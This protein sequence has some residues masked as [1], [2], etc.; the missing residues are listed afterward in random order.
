MSN[1]VIT[2]TFFDFPVNGYDILQ[3]IETH[4][5]RGFF[6]VNFDGVNEVLISSSRL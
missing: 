6:D 1:P 2:K 3:G 4:K 5:V